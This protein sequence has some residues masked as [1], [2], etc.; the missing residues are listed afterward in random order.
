[1]WAALTNRMDAMNTVAFCFAKR[2]YSRDAGI[3]FLL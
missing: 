3:R 2:W 1:V